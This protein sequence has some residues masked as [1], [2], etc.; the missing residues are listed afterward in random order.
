MSAIV[1]PDLD[2][3]KI[4]KLTEMLHEHQR[5]WIP[6][7]ECCKIKLKETATGFADFHFPPAF[8]I[9]RNFV[10]PFTLLATCF[11]ADFFLGLFFCPR[12]WRRYVPPKRRLTFKRTTRRYIPE[13]RTLHNLK[14]YIIPNLFLV[15]DNSPVS[16][17]V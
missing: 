15:W 13:D 4:E 12:R 11:D 17:H 7:C 10:K 3:K 16:I 8:Y 14:S 9:F 2:E 6:N 5:L 1:T